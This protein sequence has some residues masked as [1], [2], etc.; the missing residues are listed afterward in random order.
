MAKQ[1]RKWFYNSKEWRTVRQ[2][3][4]HRDHFTCAYCKGRAT[5]VHHIIELNDKNIH[6]PKVSL[7]LDNLQS[8]C[9]ECHR[10]ITMN[11]HHMKNLDCEMNYYFDDE[12]NLQKIK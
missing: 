5:E 6:D 1:S 8:L 12:G 4:L 3:A 2:Q 10:Q 7:N 11:E 9:H